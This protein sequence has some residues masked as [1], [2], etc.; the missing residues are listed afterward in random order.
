MWSEANLR[1]W[2]AEPERLVPETLMPHLAISNPAEQVY[3]L[4][5]LMQ[6]K[7]PLVPRFF[8]SRFSREGSR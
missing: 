2:I 1:N 5:Y 7:T 4:A 6:L 3:L 8:T